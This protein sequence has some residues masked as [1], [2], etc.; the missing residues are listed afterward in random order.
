MELLI[1]AA[2]D[3]LRSGDR[4]TVTLGGLTAA[5]LPLHVMA[6][7]SAGRAPS[8]CSSTGS[9]ENTPSSFG[10][11]GVLGLATDLFDCGDY[12]T[13]GA[14][15]AAYYACASPGSCVP[16]D[17][18]LD[19]QV[20]NPVA[21]LPVDNNGT[22]LE[23][24]QVPLAGAPGAEG[25]LVLGIGTRANNALGSA[26]VLALSD[27]GSITTKY[28]TRDYATSFLDSGTN[29][30]AFNDASIPACPSSSGA[31]G[32]LCPPSPLMLDAA[33]SGAGGG[34]PAPVSFALSSADTLLAVADNWA[35][36]DIG[37]PGLDATTFDWGLPFYFGRRVFTALSGAST[38]GGAGP[39]VA[40]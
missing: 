34:T 37:E 40:Y 8:S 27:T 23:L 21:R 24:P 26:T 11:N 20:P 33:N 31:A 5:G 2:D 17:A 36:S 25:R 18:P 9:A 12:C 38:P 16:V 19:A 7:G 29:A 13:S 39:F 22:V 35:F 3:D 30:L 6:D 15:E 10:A 32:F 14:P 28:G 4:L 1:Y